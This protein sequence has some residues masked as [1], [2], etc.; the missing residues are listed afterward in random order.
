[1]TG[2]K[3]Q[4]TEEEWLRQKSFIRYEYVVIGTSL[5][6]LT[7]ALT[8]RGHHT[9]KA[10]LEYKLK[11]WNISK[12]IDRKAWQS[13]DRKINK[14]KHDGKNSDVIFCGKRLKQPKVDKEISRHRETNIFAQVAKQR[15]PPSS[16]T[17]LQLIVCTP[18]PLRMESEWPESLPWLGFRD[19]YSKWVF[20][21]PT[22]STKALRR[23][24]RLDLPLSL[25][26]GESIKGRRQK[27]IASTS[28]SELASNIG[29]TM[30][31]WYPGEHIQIAH[32]H[33]IESGKE[34]VPDCVK[35]IIYQMSNGMKIGHCEN[36]EA[37]Y[38]FL[39]GVGL[40][41]SPT[42]LKGLRD[43]NV[44]IRAFMDTLFQAAIF[45]A[46]MRATGSFQVV[47]WLLN[48]GQDPNCPMR[49][50]EGCSTT[51]LQE[52]IEAGYEN[53]VALLLDFHANVDVTQKFSG[54]LSVIDL[55]VGSHRLPECVKSGMFSLLLPHC[56]SNI[57]NALCAAIRLHEKEIIFQ[58]LQQNMDF[59]QGQKNMDEWRPWLYE[60]TPL[61][62]AIESG[63]DFTNILLDHLSARHRSADF[64][65]PD[66]FIAAAVK[67]DNHT[68]YRLDQ[69]YPIGGKCNQRGITP[70]QAAVG[71]GNISTCDLLLQLYGGLSATLIY[72]ASRGGHGG[73][74]RF[75]LRK[76]A[77]AD[78]IIN[79]GDEKPQTTLERLL[80]MPAREWNNFNS[81]CVAILIENGAR[82]AG[83]EVV[84]FAT[85]WKERPLRAALAAGASP[86]EKDVSGRSALQ[87]ALSPVVAR[88]YDPR[89]LLSVEALLDWRA[90]LLGG[91]VVQAIRLEN[92]MLVQRLLRLG[93]SLRDTGDNGVSC[94]EAAIIAQ[95]NMLVQRILI[96]VGVHYDAGSLC[97][98]LQVENLPLVDRILS[99][100]PREAD[101]LPLEATA[102]GLAAKSGNL[103]IL[104][105]L[106]H[107]TRSS[108]LQSLQ[109]ASLPFF[110][111]S[112]GNLRNSYTVDH[113]RNPKCVEGSPLAL[114]LILGGD[115]GFHEL[116][117]NGYRA[118]T[119]TWVVVINMKSIAALELLGEYQQRLDS[120]STLNMRTPLCLAVQKQDKTLIQYLLDAG[121]DVN[122]YDYTLLRNRS[123]LQLAVEL[124]N[125][126]IIGCL[127][128]NGAHVNAVPAFYGG[129]TA[130][131]LAAINGHLGVANQLLNHGARVNARGARQRGR[132]ALEAAAEHGRLDMLALLLHHGAL[133]TGDGRHQFVRAVKLAIDETHEATAEWL[134]C[135]GV[136][137]QED[138]GLLQE[139]R[140]LGDQGCKNCC[141]Y[142]CDEIHNSG[143]EC[144]HAFSDDEEKFLSDRCGCKASGED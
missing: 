57:Q 72:I 100:R 60:N 121:A 63:S 11:N 118:D 134:K 20:N 113:W 16:P 98:A 64:V 28:I 21:K 27:S 58:I 84:A 70:L 53:L 37:V 99:T 114:A 116:L 135:R 142:C 1:M 110:L 139:N 38:D 89:Q 7:V 36:W 126:D 127:L 119:F 138:E 128:G 73:M 76:G 66:V 133:I 141:Q 69:I 117:K 131:Q 67:G 35:M 130:L 140:L 83:G 65:T 86:D 82:L 106:L 30:P 25:M 3:P 68:T 101:Y 26:A 13:I 10:Q 48:S 23:A 122:D 80:T 50:E 94:L 47:K 12:N 79:V 14:R 56:N 6:D 92:M 107:L 8:S 45:H 33:L 54:G 105:K 143:S 124:G 51:A 77:D 39:V 43:Q 19:V 91:E 49:K 46:R 104:R 112:D 123:P 55:A 42:D 85:G 115:S 90:K 5:K 78:A 120:L 109:S 52:A 81:S 88:S 62:A 15:S 59:S 137:T 129:A 144:I 96:E 97:A 132:T 136:W 41:D 95:N 24:R 34:S 103:D 17:N 2:T 31:E 4:P 9:T 44:T 61:S 108:G 93:G 111:D 75:L 102:I 29:K 18:P 74:L 22:P 40:L 87:R 32:V 125:L 71:W